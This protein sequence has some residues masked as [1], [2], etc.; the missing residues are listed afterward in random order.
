MLRASCWGQGLC[1]R[2]LS[3]QLASCSTS[4]S[5]WDQA[6]GSTTSSSSSSSGIPMEPTNPNPELVQKLLEPSMLNRRDRLQLR[7]EAIMK[8]YQRYDGDVGS[9]EVQVALLTERIR[10][11]STHFQTHKKDEHSRR[12]L[13]GLL[14]QRRALLKYLRASNFP[15]FCFVI[16][17]LGLKDTFG[18]QARY[19]NYRVGSRLG[20]PAEPRKKYGF[21]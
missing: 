7:K 21:R 2:L 16:H 1:D 11:L 20:V 5:T 18:K 3:H 12:G 13:A 10:D 15:R 19:D 6:L 8:E 9:P 14:N 17:K 4:C